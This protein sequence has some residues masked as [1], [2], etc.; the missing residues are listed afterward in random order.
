LNGRD[1]CQEDQGQQKRNK[2][3]KER[4]KRKKKGGQDEGYKAKT[5]GGEN[6]KE[7]NKEKR[8][9]TEKK[10]RK[11][12]YSHFIILNYQEKL[13]RQM[14]QKSN[15]SSSA[16]SAPPIKPQVKLFWLKLEL[17]QTSSKK[18]RNRNPPICLPR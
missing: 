10:E 12:Y 6:N 16:E 18:H 2:I 8:N 5:C 11:R 9:K 3:K 13:F 1:K 17:Y 14:V 7:S 15:F 4:Q